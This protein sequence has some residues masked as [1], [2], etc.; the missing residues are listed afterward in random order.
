MNLATWFK[1]MGVFVVSSLV[2]S[3]AATQL[4]PENFNLSKAGLAKLGSLILV[5]GIKSVLLY[6]KQSPLPDKSNAIANWDKISSAIVLALLFPLALLNT[7]CVS[8][9]EQDTFAALAVD[10]AVVDCA[11]AG[12]NHFDADIQHACF[13]APDNPANDPTKFYLPQTRDAQQAIEKARQVQV[14]CVEAFQGYAVAK[15]GKD[16]SIPLAQKQAVVTSYLA[17]L[18]ALVN[19]LRALMGA[20]PAA[21]L[22]QPDVADPV[23]AITQLRPEPLP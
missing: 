3:L 14:A 5:I 7:G 12:Y 21:R 19:A 2:T 22:Q 6:L 4:A 8:S 9:W 13:A 1:G 11:V 23:R 17:Q 10:K 18:P 15:V 16:K 20:T